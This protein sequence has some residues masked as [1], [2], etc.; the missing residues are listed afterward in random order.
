MKHITY[1]GLYKKREDVEM[2]VQLALPNR[3]EVEFA[4]KE[5]KRNKVAAAAEAF[6]DKY[7]ETAIVIYAL[8]RRL[9][10]ISMPKA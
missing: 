9:Y 4:Y 7:T 3:A 10:S 8:D 5:A 2:D 6:A 1:H